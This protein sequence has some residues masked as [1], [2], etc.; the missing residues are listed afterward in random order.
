MQA[1]TSNRWFYLGIATLSQVILATIHLGIPAILPLIQTEF[2]LSLTEVGVLV[3]L[4]NIGVVATAI[5]AG[6]AADRFGERPIIGYGTIA[7]GLIIMMVYFTSSIFSLVPVL[8]LLGVPFGSATPAGSKAVAGWFEQ[9]ERGT[10]MSIRQTGVPVGGTIA[11]LVLP[12]LGLAYGWRFALSSVGVLA[13]GVGIAVLKFYKEPAHQPVHQDAGTIG[14]IKDIVRRKDIWVVTLYAAI[15][16]GSQWCYLS[17][18][19]LYL[20]EDINFPLV[21]AAALLAGGQMLGAIGRIVS[22]LFSD[23]FFLGERKPVLVM[24]GL[25]A[26][27]LALVTVFLS[28]GTPRW[29][30]AVIVAFL[31][32]ATMSWQGLYLA[33]ISEIVGAR[34]AGQAIGLT[35]TVVFFGIVCLPPVFGTIADYTAS[36]QMAWGWLALVIAVPLIFFLRER[37]LGTQRT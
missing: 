14:G 36:Y 12:S 35:N 34:M 11:A 27:V 17:Y 21:L 16:G 3:S 31:G 37:S 23:R 26:I 29:T 24:L 22:G 28:P 19:E 18:I 7:G 13:I 6:K 15:L 2:R 25:L 33:L 30:V 9:R 1:K 20:T 32:F 10:A 5:W 8:L 4:V